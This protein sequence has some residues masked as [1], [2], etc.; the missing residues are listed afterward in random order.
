[1]RDKTGAGEDEG[2]EMMKRSFTE[3]GGRRGF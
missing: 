3:A 1:M 2:N